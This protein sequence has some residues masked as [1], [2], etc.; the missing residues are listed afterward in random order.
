MHQPVVHISGRKLV[1]RND[2][3]GV[4]AEAFGFPDFYGRNINAWHDCMFSLETPTDR[5]STEH[6]P[7]AGTLAIQLD[8][9]SR[10]KARRPDFI[11]LVHDAA[12]FVNWAKLQE[13]EQAVLTVAAATESTEHLN[14]AR[15]TAG[16]E[17]AVDHLAYEQDRLILPQPILG[18][19]RDRVTGSQQPLRELASALGF[20]APNGTT[21]A[22]VR[23]ILHE[24]AVEGRFPGL[25]DAPPSAT[26]VLDVQ[27]RTPLR[28]KRAQVWGEVL[29]LVS[30]VNMDLIAGGRPRRL[31][32]RSTHEPASICAAHRPPALCAPSVS[33]VDSL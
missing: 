15:Q 17:V 28:G 32:G 7:R 31:H 29:E 3:H 13:G 24:Y 21:M 25:S 4:F 11:E 9:Y 6:A 27:S 23:S 8:E 12:A 10:L 16:D 18:I 22:W 14:A 19:D 1:D 5:M 33:S 2:F 30:L 20:A 26:F